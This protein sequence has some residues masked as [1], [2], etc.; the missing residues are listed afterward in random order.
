[1]IDNK[2]NNDSERL[3]VLKIPSGIMA[4]VLVGA[5]GCA[6]DKSGAIVDGADAGECDAPQRGGDAAQTPLPHLDPGSP[7]PRAVDR[8]VVVLEPTDGNQ[9]GGIIHFVQQGDGVALTA[10]VDGLTTGKH[11]YH[12]HVFGDCTKS[13][14]SS[15]G[16]HLNFEGSSLQPSHDDK[17]AITGN[18]GDLVADADGKATAGQTIRGASLSGPYSIIG[19]S[20]VIH[21]LANDPAHPPM[22]ATGKRVACGVIGIAEP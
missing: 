11:A 14:G 5:L 8:A 2:A 3:D 12:V 13:D 21:E 4:I 19:R 22:G 17:K 18:L 9:A 10:E 1:M 16:T 7:E 6:S 15:A 20:V